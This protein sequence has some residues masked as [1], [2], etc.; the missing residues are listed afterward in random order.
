MAYGIGRYLYY[1]GCGIYTEYDPES[2]LWK[3]NQLTAANAN[4][5]RFNEKLALGVIVMLIFWLGIYPQPFLKITEQVSTDIT[6][7]ILQKPEII[8]I[9]KEVTGSY[10]RINI[11]GSFGS[12]Y[13]VQRF[14]AETEKRCTQY[15]YSRPVAIAYGEYS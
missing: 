2:I 11:I 9:L 8:H 3:Y 6:N 13:D 12:Y 10:E 15:C 14:A 1:S 7:G 4:D 5:I